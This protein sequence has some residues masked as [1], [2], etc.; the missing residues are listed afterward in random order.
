MFKRTHSYTTYIGNLIS[1]YNANNFLSWS[2]FLKENQA[3]QTCCTDTKT[4]LKHKDNI[5][6]SIGFQFLDKSSPLEKS[7]TTCQAGVHVALHHSP[8]QALCTRLRFFVD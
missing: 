4:H 3:F 1:C 5:S 8:H 6:S 7:P 2:E